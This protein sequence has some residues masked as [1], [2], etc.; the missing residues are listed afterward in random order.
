MGQAGRA[1]IWSAERYEAEEEKYLN[2]EAI[3]AVMEELGF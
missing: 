3:A 2:P 1:E